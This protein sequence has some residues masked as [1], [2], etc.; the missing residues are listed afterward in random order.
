MKILGNVINLIVG[1]LEIDHKKIIQYIKILH[2]TNMFTS[3]LIIIGNDSKKLTILHGTGKAC[4]FHTMEIRYHKNIVVK[5]KK[6][7]QAL[8][9]AYVT[10]LPQLIP[11]GKF[12]KETQGSKWY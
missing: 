5:V 7:R 6:R 2:K 8:K 1:I 12:V 4:K 11:M 3:A 10:F 9:F